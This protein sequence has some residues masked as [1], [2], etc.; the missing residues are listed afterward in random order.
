MLINNIEVIGKIAARKFA[1]LAAEIE[2]ADPDTNK[3]VPCVQLEPQGA[4]CYQYVADF[5][6]GFQGILYNRLMFSAPSCCR[7]ERITEKV[8]EKSEIENN[9]L[10]RN[11]S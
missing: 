5:C 7:F 2:R 3:I 6:T 9:F 4:L 8:E 10:A 11:A 1:D